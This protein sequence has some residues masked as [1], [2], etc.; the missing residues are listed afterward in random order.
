[1][2]DIAYDLLVDLERID[3]QPGHP[4]RLAEDC[5]VAEIMRLRGFSEVEIAV[6]LGKLPEAALSGVTAGAEVAYKR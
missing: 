4:A 3:S 1:M 5:R 6:S 2:A